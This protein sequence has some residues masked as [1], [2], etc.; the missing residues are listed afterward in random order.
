VARTYLRF[1][2]TIALAI[3][4]EPARIALVAVDPSL[5][6]GSAAQA[7]GYSTDPITGAPNGISSNGLNLPNNGGGFGQSPY[8][9]STYGPTG[10][11]RPT[12]PTRPDSWPGGSEDPG[13]VRAAGPNRAATA[14][15]P[16]YPPGYKR[17]KSPADPPYDPAEIIAYVGTEVIQA[18]ELLPAVNEH[19][20]AFMAQAPAGFQELTPAEKE[21]QINRGRRDLMEKYTRDLVKVKLLI[22]DI[23]RKIPPE[24]VTKHEA[25]FR[26]YFNTTE[27]K[28][29]M[30]KFKAQSVIDLDT[31][32]RQQGSSLDAQRI[33]FIERCLATGWLGQQ[34]K[35]EQKEATHELMLS[36]YR[37][38]VGDWETP[39]R[40]RWEQLTVKFQNYDSKAAARGAL[41]RWGNEIQRG[42]PF[43]AVAKAHSQES[44]ADEG[45]VHD[46]VS[47]G[48]LKSTAL[49]ET[50]FA[51]PIGTLSRIV[52]D[53]EG[54]HI[55]RVLAREESQRSP[56]T[57]VQG[58]IKKALQDTNQDR[59]RNDY[60]EKLREQ[61]PVLTIF[62][63]DFTARTSQPAATTQPTA[64]QP[65]ATAL[66]ANAPAANPR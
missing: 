54:L 47:K 21:D 20:A 24:S 33:V 29:M 53:E 17:K 31:K 39:A 32:L 27:I 13:R 4:I 46:W 26:S 37:E 58:D 55:V 30:A 66:P 45:G 1:L 44:S 14:V 11:S 16:N 6:P 2:A 36:Y 61:T 5:T 49:D 22:A 43:A 9:P 28:T 3:V 8:V 63:E 51:L 19:I 42:A 65:T 15:I 25:Q 38:H 23:H 48:S 64:N 57:R 12:T 7:Q 18:N 10:P 40:V 41:A 60:V 62:D 34:V 59:Q 52:E 50:L 35:D 56:F